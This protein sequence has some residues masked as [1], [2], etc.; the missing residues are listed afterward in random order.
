[1][2]DAAPPV[3]TPRGA[4][5]EPSAGAPFEAVRVAR[6]VLHTSRTAALATLDPVSGYPYTT[7]TNI[8]IEPDGTPFFFA[9]GLTLHARNM[10]A[11][12]RI[13]LT[14]APFGKG[15]A[16][17]LPRLTLVGK[18]ELIDLE[19]VP[20]ARQRYIDRYPKAKLYLSLPDTR[21][22]RLRTEGVQINGGPARN[23]SNITPADLRTDL[24]DAEQLMA[25]AADEAARLNAIKGEASRLAALAGEKT[26]R[27][28]I[29]SID[30]DGIDLASANDLAR[31]WFAERV[32]TLK[33]LEKALA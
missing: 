9:A 15:D 2:P 27:W 29:I 32:K 8:G 7:A 30:P 18:A 13:S 28:K 22:Y 4:K 6:D 3:I 33:Q 25:A 19:E 10:E 17:T 1:M 16:L 5:I 21:L 24:S 26:A 31:L 14:L 20:L 11:D 12:P 23:A